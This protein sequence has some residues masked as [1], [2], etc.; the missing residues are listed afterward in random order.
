MGNIDHPKVRASTTC[1]LCHGQKATG[2]VV[3][4]SCYSKRRLKYGNPNAEATID[5]AEISYTGQ[6]HVGAGERLPP[7]KSGT[8]F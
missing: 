1:P 6:D 5:R 7:L 8:Q 3:C 4:W 2:L